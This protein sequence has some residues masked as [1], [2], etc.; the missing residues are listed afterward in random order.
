MASLMLALTLLVLFVLPPRYLFDPAT[1]PYTLH[2]V[3]TALLGALV[4]F[5]AMQISRR[6]RYREAGVLAVICGT[7]LILLTVAI[8]GQDGIGALYF[9]LAMMLFSSVFY[10]PQAT[11]LIGLVQAAAMIVLA[12]F[13][14]EL[15][16]HA[17]AT[18]PV[19]FHMMMTVLFVLMTAYNKRYILTQQALLR[20][21]QERY[22]RLF[23]H[24]PV[25]IWDM[26]LS[27]LLRWLQGLP[28]TSAAELR[29]H[30]QSDPDGLPEL[31]HYIRV[32]NV[33]LAAVKMFGAND[34]EHLLR[35]L[36]QL[37]MEETVMALFNAL[38]QLWQGKTHFDME[39][40][41]RR[42]DGSENDYLLNF[43]AAGLDDAPDYSHTIMAITEVTA[44]KQSEVQRVRLA[45][46]RERLALTG[47]FVRA[48]SHDF[49][50]SLSN[51]EINRYLMQR[52]LPESAQ[53]A[54]K[55]KL[56]MIAW[57]VKRLTE[58]IE[59]LY[60]VSFLAERHPEPASVNSVV[61]KVLAELRPRLQQKQLT[62]EVDLDDKLPPILL[63]RDEITRAMRHMLDNAI[64]YTDPGGQVIVRTTQARDYVL[65]RVIDSGTGIELEHLP[66]IFDLFYRADAARALDAGGIGL[67]LSIVKMVAEAH[68]GSVTVQSAP[69]EGSVFTLMLPVD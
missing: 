68:R 24:S 19:L 64:N 25:A 2:R 23:E 1:A 28:V 14:P 47:R 11:L 59:N 58:Q 46:E 63:D 3:T 42:Y 48:V 10:G 65:I 62:L 52:A 32:R 5:G 61:E 21:S 57:H 49:R 26:D 54:L 53:E 7:L 13:T 29:A 67:G 45:V 15:D 12:A 38:V 30:L 44:S 17:V 56:D 4:T 66:H 8:I 31:L 18:G 39:F 69:G 33:N 43:Y 41:A 6:G 50:T 36:P 37:F 22:Q 16:L 20:E 51:I 40:R 55:P 60:T 35:N 9:M 34:T 27:R